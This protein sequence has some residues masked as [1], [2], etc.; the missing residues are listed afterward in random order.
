M[1]LIGRGL[2]LCIFG[3]FV[4]CAQDGRQDVPPLWGPAPGFVLESSLEAW[5]PACLYET[6]M[7]IRLRNETKNKSNN[8]I[9]KAPPAKKRARWFLLIAVFTVAAMAG[10]QEMLRFQSNRQWITI[11]LPNPPAPLADNAAPGAAQT[12]TLPLS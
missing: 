3:H 12:G 10:T 11:S 7:I 9:S 8:I 2:A 1:V 5:Q 4:T 6:I